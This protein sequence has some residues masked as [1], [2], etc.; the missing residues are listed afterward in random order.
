ML[1][2]LDLWLPGYLRR[3]PPSVATAP[4]T[5]VMFA[6]GDHFE[7]RHDSDAAGALARVA[8]WQREYPA[9]VREFRGS[10]GVCPRHTFF[11]P[12]EQYDPELLTRIADVCAATGS[13]LE[14]HLHHDRDTAQGLRD[15]LAQGKEDLARHGG[16]ARDEAGRLRFGFI[17]GNWA[18]AHSHPHGRACGVPEELTVLREAGCYA[19]FTLPSAPDR[20]QTK[21]VNALY[22]ASTTG[23]P[24]PHDTGVPAR[25]APGAKP[26]RRG[27]DHRDP[28]ELLLVQGPLALNWQRRKYGLLPR[29]ENAEV[30][31]ANPPTPDRLRLWLDTRIAVEGRPEWVFIKLHT[32]GGIPPN[33][34][35]LL[36]D[37]M[38]RF[39]AHL[40]ERAAGPEGF[41]I[42][43]VTTR[44]MV[45]ILHA[46]EDGATGDAGAFRNYRYMANRA[47]A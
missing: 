24:K 29:I 15:K 34:A 14:V 30:S 9:L 19:D 36:G 26:G 46:A 4:I 22:Y 42:H 38:R 16:L 27:P 35:T 17:H 7:P 40:L 44:E 20:T 3:T 2:A 47:P 12:I 33:M 32:H 25:V 21:T 13:E 18:L 28:G 43:F 11:Y 41:R 5:D 37:P 8:R 39:Y 23:R 31:G 10:G 6:I 45:N 1:R